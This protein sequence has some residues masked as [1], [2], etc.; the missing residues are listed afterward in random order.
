MKYGNEVFNWDNTITCVNCGM[1]KRIAINEGY[2]DGVDRAILIQHEQQRAKCCKQPDYF[3][4]T[5]EQWN[6]D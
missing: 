5:N 2:Q 4:Y 1:R 3:M 6:G